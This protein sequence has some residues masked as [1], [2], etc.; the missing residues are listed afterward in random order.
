MLGEWGEVYGWRKMEIL[1]GLN[2]SARKLALAGLRQRFPQAG[3]AEL[4][5]RL[6]D[7]FLGVDLTRK[8]YG[9]LENAV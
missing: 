6:A 1:A 9:D 2:A 7:L 4:H 5:R 3:E 8:V